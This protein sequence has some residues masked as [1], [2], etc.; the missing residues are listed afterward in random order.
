MNNH[1]KVEKLGV[2]LSP[3]KNE[4]EAVSV[5]NPACYQEGEY[6]HVFYRAIDSNHKSAIGY[7]K[8]KGPTE[9]VERWDKPIIERVCDYE[10]HGIEDPRIVK[11]GKTFYLTYVA[12][13]G[14]NAIVAYATSTDLKNF[15][16]QGIISPKLTYDDVGDIFEKERLKDRYLMFEAYYKQNAGRN[17][18]LW[19]KDAFFFPKKI[20]RKFALIHRILPDIHIIFFKNFNELKQQ[21]FWKKYLE[22]LPAHVV[23]ENKFWFESRNIGGGAPPIETKDGWILIYHS[24]EELNRARIYH[25]S[26]ALLDKN[27]PAKAI[28]RL[29]YP[30]FSP[31]EKWEKQGFVSNVVFPTGTAIFDDHLYIYYGAADKHIA[32]ARIKLSSLLNEL[33]NKKV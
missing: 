16:R 33:K 15:E 17:V 11:I 5:L 22:N 13:D 4:F 20:K 10:S 25:A 31:E 29:D 14:K 28:G 2:I 7:A 32:V 6:V 21:R 27:D 12:H 23:L 1:V 30:L 3:T 19:E 26:A 9:V 24:V 8:L 18:L